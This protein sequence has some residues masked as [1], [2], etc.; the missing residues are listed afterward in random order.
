[1]STTTNDHG[2]IDKSGLLSRAGE[3]ALRMAVD[4]ALALHL[5]AAVFWLWFSPKGFTI[6]ASQFWTNSILPFATLGVASAGLVGMHYGRRSLAAGTIL[7]FA[8]AW[9]T[10]AIAARLTFPISLSTIWLLL[11]ATGC[12]GAV[13]FTL[14]V[15]DERKAFSHWM[16]FAIFGLA[17]GVLVVRWQV[18]ELPSTR[19]WSTTATWSPGQNLAAGS[20]ARLSII[21]GISFQP[22]SAKLEFR[23]GPLHVQV[24]PLLTFDRISRDHF[25]SLFAPATPCRRLIARG[26]DAVEQVYFYDDRAKVV[27][28]T[29]RR[30]VDIELDAYSTL[31]TDVYSHLNRFSYIEI[32]GHK[33]LAFSFSPCPQITFDVLPADYPVGRPARFAY[34]DTAEQFH[35]CEAYSGEKGPFRDLASGRLKRDEPLTIG[36]HDDGQQVA[37]IVLD[38]WSAQVSTAISPTAGWGIAVNAIEFQRF[39]DAPTEAAGIWIT[40]AATSVG[41]GF[42]TV[43][44]AAGMYRNRIS[45]RRESTRDE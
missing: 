19:P 14:I 35:V 32:A 21:D 41:R 20:H 42:E 25:W 10:A 30:G 6:F 26:S 12:A 23:A 4:V 38:D 5:A 17:I 28:S 16:L 24:L 15:R 34:L 9:T 33:S 44:H 40:L 36:L 43:G 2:Q 45:I 31:E 39:G 13:L 37:T 18:P 1:M 3:L 7:C 11:L 22:D 29:R 8:T 27:I